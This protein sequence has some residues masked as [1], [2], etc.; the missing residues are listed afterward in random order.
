MVPAQ[1]PPGRRRLHLPTVDV[2][3]LRGRGSGTRAYQR[4]AA[5]W[6]LP[7]QGEPIADGAVLVGDDGRIAAIGPDAEVPAPSDV[8]RERFE[9]AILLPGFINTHTH[10]ELDGLEPAAETI[11]FPEWIRRLRALKAERTPDDFLAAARDGVREGWSQGVTT[12]ADCGDT[13][14]VAQALAEL[15][16]RGIAY[17][18]VFGPH[19]AQVEESLA[20]LKRRVEALRRFASERVRIGVSPHA[21]YTVSG[22]LFRAVSEWARSQELPLCLHL[23]ESE[24]ESELLGS[25]SGGFAEMWRRREIPVPEWSGTPIQWVDR[26]GVLGESTL[27]VHV[28]RAGAEDLQVLRTR[29]SAVA[30]CPL[31]NRAHRHGV[32]PLGEMRR[33]GI[34]VGV[35]TDSVVSVGRLDLR[36][37]ARAALELAGLMWSEALALCT[38]DAARALTM[39]HEVGTLEPGKWG[40][41]SVWRGAGSGVRG[42]GRPDVEALSQLALAPQ[43]QCVA[44]FIAGTEVWR[45]G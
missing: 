10:L 11:S 33:L 9:N 18:E 4:L 44:T 27:C 30:H 1:F 17:H 14:A 39:G 23:A 37:E 8:R 26:H 2:R 16:G 20:G 35:G 13:G 36:A 7:H 19:P 5:S 21:P 22:P 34:P 28:V 31:S 41:V 15:G 42:A 32:A 38:A 6:V 40:D 43:T 25:Q 29:G 3:P 12:V 24:E 45:D